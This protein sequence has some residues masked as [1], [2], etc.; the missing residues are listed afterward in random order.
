M[1][2]LLFTIQEYL[3]RFVFGRSCSGCK[4]PGESICSKCLLSIPLSQDTDHYG[5]YG[6]YDYGNVLVSEAIWNLKYKHKG[7]EAKLLTKNASVLLSEIIA[8][9]LQ[10]DTPSNI[11]LVPVPQY[12][13]K[14]ETRGFNQS[15]LIAKW[16]A[17]EIPNSKV[18]EVLIKNKETV[19]QSHLSDRKMRLKNIANTMV[20]KNKVDRDKIYI[21]VDDVTTTGAT[22]LEA[23]RALKSAGAKNILCIALAHGY[24][25]R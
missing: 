18:Q 16:F 21:V 13:K 15:T 8:E 2:K 12:R 20:V 19:P 14:T 7:Q 3:Y 5:I 17:S 24:K 23:T 1:K 4:T 9:H 11:V 22:F 25:R 6:L 10:S